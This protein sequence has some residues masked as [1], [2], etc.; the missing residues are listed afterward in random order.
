MGGSGAKKKSC[1]LL[2]FKFK[3]RKA[4]KIGCL[5]CVCSCSPSVA[6]FWSSLDSY[7]LRKQQNTLSVWS[8]AFLSGRLESSLS[9]STRSCAS[10]LLKSANGTKGM[11]AIGDWAGAGQLEGQQLVL[12]TCIRRH[13]TLLS[14]LCF[15]PPLV[16]PVWNRPKPVQPKTMKVIFFFLR[17]KKVFWGE[18]GD[19]KQKCAISDAFITVNVTILL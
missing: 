8:P 3:R 5:V 17:T 6:A 1:D 7:R 14:S 12:V 2:F 18:K 9:Q 11:E 19:T 4:L 13:P 16:S 10:P 15:I